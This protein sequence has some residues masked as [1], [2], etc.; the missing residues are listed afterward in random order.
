MAA[1][2]VIVREAQKLQIIAVSKPE[3]QTIANV[4]EA[5]AKKTLLT[6]NLNAKVNFV[7]GIEAGIRYLQRR[8]QMSSELFSYLNSLIRM[9]ER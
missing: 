4:L 6:S 7:T 2:R 3:L 5:F 8:G 9:A 1:A